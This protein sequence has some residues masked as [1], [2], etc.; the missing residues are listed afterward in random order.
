VTVQ[1]A[2]ER[3]FFN[4]A[5]FVLVLEPQGAE[6]GRVKQGIPPDQWKPL[7]RAVLD[8][9][10]AK[11]AENGKRL[12]LHGDPLLGPNGQQRT[13]L[14]LRREIGG[15]EVLRVMQTVNLP[16]W[17]NTPI[18]QQSGLA[19]AVDEVRDAVDLINGLGRDAKERDLGDY[20]VAGAM[21]N[22]R[23]APA[24]FCGSPC[25]GGRPVPADG[26]KTFDLGVVRQ[27]V[28][29][30]ARDLPAGRAAGDDAAAVVRVAIFDTWPADD[31]VPPDQPEHALRKIQACR[32]RLDPG[33][34]DARLQRALNGMASVIDCV[35][36]DTHT[37][38]P[39]AKRDCVGNVEPE[40]DLCDHG[41]FVA[42]IVDQI[43]GGQAEIHVYRA[44]TDSGPTT[45]DILAKAIEQA[46]YYAPKDGK[47]ILNFSLGFGL[48]LLTVSELLKKPSDFLDDV[49]GWTKWAGQRVQSQPADPTDPT[50]WQPWTAALRNALGPLYNSGRYQGALEFLQLLFSIESMDDVLA[51]A[52]AGN[53]SC[54]PDRLFPP[55][56]PAVFDEILGVSAVA[57]NGG[58]SPFSNADDDA[59]P[60]D[61]IS[62]L[63]GVVGGGGMS[64]PS[65]GL[66]G[67]YVSQNFPRD[68]QSGVVQPNNIGRAVWAGTSFAT[69]VVTGIAARLWMRDGSLTPQEII[70][71]IV[72]NQRPFIPHGDQN[73]PLLQS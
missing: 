14:P 6:A 21:P 51:I 25:P 24:G 67:L 73:T 43:T 63:G 69:P 70:D 54:R 38:A 56:V 20:W 57:N 35:Y 19:P 33:A 12:Q 68:L 60:D 27:T 52:A 11:L 49:T 64:D 41:L 9:L 31:S 23:A 32:D 62:A 15:A 34:S 10:L 13:A 2:Q 7:D 66:V 50:Q 22:W 1:Q 40:Y 42:D 58:M 65:Q 71:A 29:V 36:D 53:N 26:L 4:P 16:S 39:L 18:G 48:D 30:I 28:E 46:L 55:L 61:G 45:F 3:I 5:E 37:A 8:T 17:S 47:L 59:S 44:L 72:A